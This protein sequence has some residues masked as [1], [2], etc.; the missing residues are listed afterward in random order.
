MPA[1]PALSLE[2]SLALSVD[3]A[4]HLLARRM[5]TVDQ[6]GVE[7]RKLSWAIFKSRTDAASRAVKRIH[8]AAA[9]DRRFRMTEALDPE[10]AERTR[11]DIELR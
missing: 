6:H 11:V 1:F 7:F 4:Y 10:N 2:A 9:A 8:D 5:T 3:G